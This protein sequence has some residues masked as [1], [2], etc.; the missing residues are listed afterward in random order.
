MDKETLSNHISNLGKRDFAIAC[1]IVLENVFDFNVINVDGPRDGGTDFTCFT[2]EGERRSVGIQITTQKSDVKN[3]AYRDAQKCLTKLGLKKFYFLS[4]YRLSEEDSRKIEQEIEDDLDVRANVYDSS[5]IAGFLIKHS[6]VKEFLDKTDFPD[7]RQVCNSVVDYKQMALH[8]YTLL[9]SDAKNLKEQIYEDTILLVM[10]GKSDG[11]N[12]EEIVRG[13]MNLLTLPSIKEE[14][15][16]NRIDSLLSKAKI[17]KQEELYYLLPITKQEIESRQIIYEKELDT[18]A[19]VQTDIMRDYSVEWTIEDARLTSVWIANTYLSEQLSILEKVDAPLTKDLYGHIDDNGIQA[20]KEFLV[21]KKCISKDILPKII[22]AFISTAASQ[23]LMKK[24]TSAFVY[25]ALE[26]RNPMTSCRALGVNRWSD[27]KLLMEPTIGI[28]ILCSFFFNASVNRTFDNAINAFRQSRDLGIPI[29]VSY[30]YIKECAGHLHMARKYDGLDLN[31]EEMVYSSNAFVS[32]YY[33]L[34]KQ[35]IDLPNSYLDYL[36]LFSPAIKIEKEYKDWIRSMMSDIQSLF[37]RKGAATYIDIPMY[38]SSMLKDIENEYTFYLHENE[39]EKSKSLLLNDIITI[40]F[41][42]EL[43]SKGEHWMILTNDKI[44]A[45]ISKQ[46]GNEAWI[47][48]PYLFLD[49]VE[50]TKPMDEKKILSLVHSVAKYSESTLS[51]GARI[52][53]KIIFYASDKMQDW[54]FKK[55]LDTF[56]EEMVKNLSIDSIGDME[57]LD[58]MTDEFLSKHNISMEL[59]EESDIDMETFVE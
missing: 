31:P 24:I 34:K 47:T 12:Q 23:P 10:A 13:T 21:K 45:N 32:H 38:D 4:T 1:R 14:R 48:S 55:E 56:K 40:Q 9:S 33:S 8:S 51:V 50:M 29:F 49:M 54:Q 30:N 6:L 52:I 36:A 17:R 25:V 53:D 46:C 27:F 2:S 42:K 57:K 3:K 22:E 15:I 58:K 39:L 26:G 7:L 35:G 5:I 37:T 20:L 19:A 18:L 44:L 28:P 16:K 43:C 41:T 11:I 59:G